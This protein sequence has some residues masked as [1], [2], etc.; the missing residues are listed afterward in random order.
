M[1]IK[2]CLKTAK[3]N[4]LLMLIAVIVTQASCSCK[5][6]LIPLCSDDRNLVSAEVR[7]LVPLGGSIQ[8]AK[9]VMEKEGF[10][11]K[12]LFQSE[13]SENSDDTS[14]RPINIQKNIDFLLCSKTVK[15]SIFYKVTWQ[16]A[17]I[18]KDDVLSNIL[19]RKIH[20][21]L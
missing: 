21:S 6:G 3:L 17:F 8:T 11:C 1:R 7:R 16:I 5:Q 10:E 4:I 19:V 20:S 9:E 15:E 2:Q 18:V 12:M 13:F 14:Q